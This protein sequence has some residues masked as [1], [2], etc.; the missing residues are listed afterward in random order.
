MA[1]NI[2]LAPVTSFTNDSSAVATVNANNVLIQTAFLDVLG[3]SGFSPNAMQSVLDMNSFNIVNLPPPATVN[4][5]VRLVD[6]IN[7]SIALTVPPV[8]TS[9]ST[10]PLLNGLNTFG[11]ATQSFIGNA[12]TIT[13]DGAQV[14]VQ[15]SSL[16]QSTMFNP[17]TGG[18]VWDG[19]RSV[20]NIP[21]GTTIPLSANAYGAY[22]R[23]RSGAGA[24][25]GGGVGYYA[26]CTAGASNTDIWG[27]NYRF[28]DSEDASGHV[29]TGCKLIGNELDY[30]ISSAGTTIQGINVSFA[31]TIAFAGGGAFQVTNLTPAFGQLTA[32]FVSGDAVAPIALVVGASAASGVSI[33]SQNLKFNWFDSGGA[34]RACN[35][36]ADSAGILNWSN[37]T[38]GGGG[39]TLSS[40]ASTTNII[41]FVQ[42]A[43]GKWQVGTLANGNFYIFDTVAGT[44]V[45]QKPT[46]GTLTVTPNTTYAGE[47]VTSASTTARSGFNIPSGTAPTSPVDGDMW[48]DGAAIKFRIGGTTKTFTVT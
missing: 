29:Y 21:A 47:L 20:I 44:F 5:P 12:T 1:E 18:V 27:A 13:G 11:P 37:Q 38:A 30:L 33:I 39:L 45:F 43:I 36:F 28:Q 9:G 4:S 10:V 26:L 19:V 46:G 48:Y 6:V 14:I 31:S 7:P 35:L 22:I 32:A 15:N 24:S 16:T 17:V 23:N 42:N 2:T 41:N 34:E 8:G 3:R 40:A 25:V